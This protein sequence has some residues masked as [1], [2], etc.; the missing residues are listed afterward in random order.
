MQAAGATMDEIV[1]RVGRVGDV[2]GEISHA[3]A[4]QSGGVGQVAQSVTEL[5]RNTQQNA[6]LVEQG[7]AAAQSLSDQAARLVGVVSTFRLA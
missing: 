5:D 1:S 2:I 4:E 6:A 3:A 7:A